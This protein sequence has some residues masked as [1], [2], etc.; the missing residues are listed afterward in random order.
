M[1]ES[2]SPGMVVCISVNGKVEFFSFFFKVSINIT[3]VEVD[4]LHRLLKKKPCLINIIIY[5]KDTAG[6]QH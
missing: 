5:I 2:G 4:T 3:Y 1:Y 6:H